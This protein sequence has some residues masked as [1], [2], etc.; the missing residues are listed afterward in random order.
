MEKLF[1]KLQLQEKLVTEEHFVLFRD[2]QD[3]RF[4]TVE[5]KE[6]RRIIAEAE[7]V[8]DESFPVLTASMYMRFSKDGNR[9]EYQDVYHR[10]RVAIK[11]L[12]AAECIEKKGRFISKLM[13]LLWLV[14]EETSWVVPAHN[15]ESNMPI[16]CGKEIVYV[17]LFAAETSSYLAHA[18][19]YLRDAIE[20]AGGSVILERILYEINRQLIQPF[21]NHKVWWMGFGDRVPNNWNPWIVSNILA[22][23][24]LTEADFKR[25]KQIV[26]RCCI[27]LDNYVAGKPSDGGCDEGPGYWEASGGALF[28]C[29]EILDDMTGGEAELFHNKDLKKIMEYICKVHIHDKYFI[30]YADAH[31]ELMLDG[32]L[33]RRMGRRFRSDVL[34]SFGQMFVEETTIDIFSKFH[35]FRF[36]KSLVDVEASNKR[37]TPQAFN[38]FPDMQLCVLRED[39]TG[40]KGFYAWMKGGHNDESHNHNDIGSIGVYCNGKPVLIDIGIGEYTKFT[41]NEM[42]YT[43]FPIRTKDHNLPLIGSK[44]QHEGKEY[45]ADFFEADEES[46]TVRAGLAGAYENR[47]KIKKYVRT[48][49][50][51]ESGITLWEDISLKNAEEIVF[52][53]YLLNKPVEKE[54]GRI[55]LGNGVAM[56]YDDELLLR[57]DEVMLE[58]KLKQDWHTDVLYRVMFETKGS[59]TDIHTEFKMISA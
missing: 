25:K 20:A 5:R 38:L 8:L 15:S 42:R 22:C 3:R 35:L 19:Y 28:D 55:E 27:V 32:I 10:R 45:K 40:E 24:A 43:L 51:Q 7:K 53:F 23:T 49:S 16:C 26:E 52:Q 30:T 57:M 46:M 17:D 39:T 14:M 9:R 1:E 4:P 56:L 6:G 2:V 31:A 44:G 29:I 54:K 50:L 33:C 21:L 13:D 48:L 34:E 37:Y 41:F 59:I 47:D 12:L 11:I 36:F 18:Y 58:D